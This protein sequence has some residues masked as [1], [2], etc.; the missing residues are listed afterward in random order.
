[1]DNLRSQA[2]V[3]GAGETMKTDLRMV[4]TARWRVCPIG[5][6]RC[7]RMARTQHV[8][9][10]DGGTCGGRD[11]LRHDIMELRRPLADCRFVQEPPRYAVLDLDATLE[12]FENGRGF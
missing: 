6:K 8:Q 1:M 7:A 4:P 12:P 2:T 5:A 9:T 3:V 11:F 10:E